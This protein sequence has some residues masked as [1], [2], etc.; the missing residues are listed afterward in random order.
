[1]SLGLSWPASVSTPWPPKNCHRVPPLWCRIVNVV[2]WSCRAV[3]RTLDKSSYES[4]LILIPCSGDSMSGVKVCGKKPSSSSCSS[5]S[6]S[7]PTLLSVSRNCDCHLKGWWQTRTFLRHE[8]DVWSTKKGSLAQALSYSSPTNLIS[9]HCIHM[10]TWKNRGKKH[11]IWW[12][13]YNRI[14]KGGRRG[15]KNVTL[16]LWWE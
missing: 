3:T 11:S 1:M 6:S 9:H 15:I 4:S 16:K 2:R 7:V 12:F 14:K 10:R 8:C 5:S 13:Y